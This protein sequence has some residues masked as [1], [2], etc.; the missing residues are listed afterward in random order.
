MHL[1]TIIKACFSAFADVTPKFTKYCQKYQKVTN[2]EK[3]GSPFIVVIRHG[4]PFY[5][6]G[7]GTNIRF[8][9]E[10]CCIVNN[11]VTRAYVR[12]NHI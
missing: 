5:H 9:L 4:L 1:R 11:F 3:L 7:E 6:T 10:L 8:F 12:P 2:I